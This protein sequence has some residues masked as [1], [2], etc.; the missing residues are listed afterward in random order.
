M[1]IC[2]LEKAQMFVMVANMMGDVS[3]LYAGFGYGGDAEDAG[4]AFDIGGKD[5]GIGGKHIG[6]VPGEGV[7]RI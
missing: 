7:D 3:F 5:H 6:I 4:S 2:D 1:T